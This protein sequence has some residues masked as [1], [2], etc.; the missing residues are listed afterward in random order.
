MPYLTH[1][2]DNRLHTRGNDIII[3]SVSIGSIIYKFHE[4]FICWYSL[5]EI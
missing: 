1:T 4:E 5:A 2:L 3:V